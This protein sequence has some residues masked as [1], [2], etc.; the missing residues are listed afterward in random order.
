MTIVLICH[1][2]FGGNLSFLLFKTQPMIW[3]W[4]GLISK[5]VH[6]IVVVLKRAAAKLKDHT[7][8]WNIPEKNT[9]LRYGEGFLQSF[10]AF[11]SIF[12]FEFLILIFEFEFLILGLLFWVFDLTFLSM[13]FGIWT[14]EFLILSFWFWICYFIFF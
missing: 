14:F 7:R 11:K 2:W 6:Y 12:D 9:T 4:D 8:R 10:R 1:I 3:P 13:N 5:T